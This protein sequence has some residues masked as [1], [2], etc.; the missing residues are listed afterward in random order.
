MVRKKEKTLKLKA[1]TK[2]DVA[3]VLTTYIANA[4]VFMLIFV[5]ICAL[6]ALAEGKT[7]GD[8]LSSGAAIVDFA[9]IVALILAITA[10][11]LWFEDRDYLKSAANS[12]MLFLIWEVGAI[13]CYMSGKFINP[14]V[15]PFALV[16]VLTLFLSGSGMAMFSNCLTI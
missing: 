3:L 12:E 6:N 1:W 4:I 5:G 9:V 14:Y 15:R 8:T 16:S 2:K 10:L 11:Y 13:L 7:V